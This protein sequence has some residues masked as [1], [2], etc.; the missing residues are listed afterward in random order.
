MKNFTLAILSSLFL[1]S[2]TDAN[3]QVVP[4]KLDDLLT[5]TLDS[6]QKVLKSKSL[7][8]SIQLSNGAVWA[9]AKGVSSEVPFVPVT[10][11]HSYLIGS[12]VKTITSACVLQL[13][14]EKKLNLDDSLFRW[15]DTFKYINPNI[16][17]RQLLRHQ[18]GI[19]DVLQNPQNQPA[20]LANKD[21]IWSYKDLITRFIKPAVFAPGKSWQY[22]NTNYFLLAMII[23]KAIGQP[24]HKEFRKRFFTP[25]DLKSFSIPAYE[26]LPS[27]IAHVWI[28]LNGDGIL[29]N[30]NTFYT[31]WKSLNAEAGSAG[32]YYAIASD[33]AK[34]TRTYFRGD[35]IS[36][37]LMT[38]A[39]QT[40]FAAGANNSNYGL[41]LMERTI[42]GLKAYGHGGD[43]SYSASTWYFPS[44]D[45]SITVLNNDSKFTSWT[46]LSTVTQLLKT[47]LAN[48]GL[49]ATNDEIE[50]NS[51]ALKVAPN[52]FSERATVLLNIPNDIH[53]LTLVFTNTLGQELASI[54]KQN[55]AA[56]E[57]RIELDE[58]AFLPNGISIM[59]VVVDGK[60][61][62]ATKIIKS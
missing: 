9:N 2:F 10:P 31:T 43:L 27:P 60:M 38:Q 54:S 1:L 3:A 14:D 17:I 50:K 49:V 15:V 30:A 22:S 5:R 20:L 32:G 24:Y 52:P 46:L 12:V 37:T 18:S 56:G 59:S 36:P 57:Q 16:T 29:D 7:S 4:K 45:I 8:A 40:V 41:G 25:L 62:K 55:L 35:L 19:Y 44:K 42:G 23:E 13:A 61:I 11:N 28:D 47:Y 48:E 34:W 58:M 33:V 21:S 6:M 53:E 26:T 51:I 39:K